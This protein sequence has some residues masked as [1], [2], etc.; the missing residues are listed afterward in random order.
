MKLLDDASLER[1]SVVANSRMNRERGAVGVNSY[2]KEL[3]L[4]PIAFLAD[5]LDVAESTSWLDLCCGRGRALIDAAKTLRS[6]HPA[7]NLSLHGVDLVDFF[8][9]TPP[10]CP[11]L[12]LQSAS[13]HMWRARQRYD[14]ITC[15]HGLHYVG[16]KLSFVESAASWLT[17]EGMFVANLDMANLRLADG[18][19][20]GRRIAKQFRECG[21]VFNHRR[22]LLSCV[23]TKSLALG[24]RY[25]GADDAAGPNYSGQE[26]VDS[27]YEP[28]S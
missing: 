8:E 5:R 16:D 28:C 25:V 3:G 24:Y 23:G 20:L 17:V 4:D 22:H 19:P 14:L 1:S 13:L 2:E 6:T 27:Y 7:S 15:V 18:Q 21:L 26:A 11:F 9:D 10:G 12:Q